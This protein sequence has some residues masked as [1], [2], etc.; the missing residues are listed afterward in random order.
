MT[1]TFPLGSCPRVNELPAQRGDR[2][3]GGSAVP[4]GGE[5]DREGAFDV[6]GYKR[7]DQFNGV[8]GGDDRRE[9]FRIPF[10]LVM[11]VVDDEGA[12]PRPAAALSPAF[13]VMR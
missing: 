7:A 1:W 13:F 5:I 10:L 2:P 9:Q 6:T 11:T 8:Y 3:L 4:V 12:R